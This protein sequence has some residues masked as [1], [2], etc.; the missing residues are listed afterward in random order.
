MDDFDLRW[1]PAR[2]KHRGF[3]LLELLVALIIAAILLAMAVPSF[4]RMQL[5][6]ALQSQG[7]LIFRLTQASRAAA[8]DTATNIT[9]CGTADF[10]RCQR[11]DFRHLMA[12]NDGN[13]SGQREETEPVLYQYSAP[14]N[15]TMY[16]RTPPQ[17]PQ[18][19]LKYRYAE[20]DANPYG[21]FYVCPRNRAMSLGQRVAVSN[22]GRNR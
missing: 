7:E 19:W 5:S 22:V 2:E 11:E 9:L 13:N 15:L 20:G 1:A 18:S 10:T 8:L 3:T 14:A 4:Q 21:S 17:M 16:L 12:F 6:S